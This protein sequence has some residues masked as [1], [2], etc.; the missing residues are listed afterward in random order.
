M[1]SRFCFIIRQSVG[2]SIPPAATAFFLCSVANVSSRALSCIH[3][4]EPNARAGVT[5]LS[6]DGQNS[7]KSC[8]TLDKD[9]ERKNEEL[10]LNT[11]ADIQ[12]CKELQDKTCSQSPISSDRV[13]SAHVMNAV[14]SLMPLI[15]EPEIR[16]D[17]LCMRVSLFFIFF[18]LT[19]QLMG[20]RRWF[21]T[22]SCSAC[23]SLLRASLLSLTFQPQPH[24][25]SLL[26][27]FPKSSGPPMRKPC[28][29][30][31]SPQRPPLG[32][33]TPNPNK[34]V[35]VCVCACICGCAQAH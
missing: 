27:S 17:L 7:I 2:G 28:P 9:A 24:L 34:C 21:I 5:S 8:F 16:I 31:S 4:G 33:T 32:V 25:T 26:I 10:Q 19:L 23:V 22:R 18:G 12:H 15:T 20:R 35:C 6:A 11:Q 1:R 29:H 30:S 3:A 13:F 14:T